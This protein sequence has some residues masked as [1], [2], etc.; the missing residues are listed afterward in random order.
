MLKIHTILC[1]KNM[2]NSLNFHY[3]C[4]LS[5]YFGYYN[6]IPIYEYSMNSYTAIPCRYSIVMN[7]CMY[8]GVCVR[9][10]MYVCVI[11]RVCL[12]V[13]VC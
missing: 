4:S 7:M 10:R 9:V 1:L 2:L 5:A 6:F 3:R 12:R 13:C 8:V 11:L